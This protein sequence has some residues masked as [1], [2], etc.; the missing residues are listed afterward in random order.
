MIGFSL[1]K[2]GFSGPTNTS[3]PKAGSVAIYQAVA[4]SC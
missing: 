3:E 4:E 2:L 1:K